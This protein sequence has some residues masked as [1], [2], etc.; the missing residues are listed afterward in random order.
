[1][2]T[3]A[4]RTATHEVTGEL[5]C[6]GIVAP[7]PLP[8]RVRAASGPQLDREIQA[9]LRQRLLIGS[10]LVL[11][12]SSLSVLLRRIF[13]PSPWLNHPH[14]LEFTCRS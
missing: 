13:P 10:G 1:M 14:A 9:L 12:A 4:D 7:V 5:G 2:A 8:V 3:D 6:G 11:A